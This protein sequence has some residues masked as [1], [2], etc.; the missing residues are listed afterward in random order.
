M[1]ERY[2][3]K[4]RRVIFFARYEASEFG[5]P[6]LDAE[7]L[8]LGILHESQDLLHSVAGQHAIE[9]IREQIRLQ[10]PVRDKISTSI[11]LPFSKTAKH[12]L[13]SAVEE[14]DQQGN[15]AITPEHILRGL[16][17]EENCPARA[18]LVKQGVTLESISHH[19]E[20]GESAADDIFGGRITGKAVPAKEFRKV[21]LNAIDEASLLRST[22]AKPE[23]LLL[24]LLR[25]EGSLAARILREAGLDYDAVRRKLS[26]PGE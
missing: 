6:A 13:N 22:A 2:S 9:S 17:R 23:H 16:L 12:V 8:L 3:Q 5:S 11:D 10:F 1:F 25:D 26:H 24:S 14:A 4:A 7:H 20:R 21:V 18:I 15:P 19:E